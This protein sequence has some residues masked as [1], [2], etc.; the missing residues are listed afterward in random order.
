MTATARLNPAPIPATAAAITYPWLA[1]RLFT[2]AVKRLRALPPTEA[3][4]IVE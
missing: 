3:P 4:E 1:A 2:V